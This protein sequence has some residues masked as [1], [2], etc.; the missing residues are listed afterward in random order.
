MRNISYKRVI[1]NPS[2]AADEITYRAKRQSRIYTFCFIVLG[3]IVLTYVAYWLSITRYDGFMVSRNVN[4][5]HSDNIAIIDYWIKPGDY[6]K[7]GDTL[8]SY[9]NVDLL[10]QSSNPYTNIEIKRNAVEAE[11]RYS[12]LYSEYLKQKKT[13][14]SLELVV[15][16][17]KV[18]VVFGV[19]TKE[20]SEDRGWD[21]LMCKMEIENTKRLL[22][23]EQKIVAECKSMEAISNEGLKNISNY[24]HI[25]RQREISRY[26]AAYSYRVAYV[27]MAIINLQARHGALI[28]GGEPT[29]T[30]MPYKNPEMLDMHIKMLLTSNQFSDIE[31]DEIYNVY[32]G[33]D[34]LGKV[35]TTYASTFVNDGIA[36]EEQSRYEYKFNNREILVRSEFL[37]PDDVDHKYHVDKNPVVLMKYKWGFLNK[38]MDMIHKK[39]HKEREKLDNKDR[40]ALTAK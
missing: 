12:R 3:I 37:N 34:F 6:V 8:Y 33:S 20:Y 27:D 21:L 16:K 25:Q 26:G 40:V 22:S 24:S 17:A 31:E 38:F 28:M 4:V 13:R 30:Y 32:V 9:V 35:R 2:A 10:N 18:D 29:I 1:S 15:E 14:D 5:R 36:I 23:I 11:G 7:E 19:A 39:Q